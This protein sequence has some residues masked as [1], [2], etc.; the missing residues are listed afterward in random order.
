MSN[1]QQYCLVDCGMNLQRRRKIV[2]TKLQHRSDQ[3]RSE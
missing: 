1:K 3:I 2:V